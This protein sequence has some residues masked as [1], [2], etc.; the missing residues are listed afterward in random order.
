MLTAGLPTTI[1]PSVH[2]CAGASDPLLLYRPL[3]FSERARASI[4]VM[5]SGVS[6]EKSAKRF[7]RKDDMRWG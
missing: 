1:S 5:R 6:S 4:S 3:D 2:R 7:G